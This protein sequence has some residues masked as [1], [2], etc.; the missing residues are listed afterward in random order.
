MLRIT[1]LAMNECKLLMFS[2]FGLFVFEINTSPDGTK[3]QRATPL[4]GELLARAQETRLM[5]ERPRGRG[6]GRG[7]GREFR[8]DRGRG[9]GR[10]RGR[11]FGGLERRGSDRRDFDRDRLGADRRDRTGADRRESSDRPDRGSERRDSF[12]RDSRYDSKRGPAVD[13]RPDTKRA[14][15]QERR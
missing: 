5:P 4:R 2:M 8:D 11:D 14:P 10:G 6:G 3:I 13:G 12:R 1:L 7:G 9:R 15:P